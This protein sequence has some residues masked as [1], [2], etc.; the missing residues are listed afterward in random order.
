MQYKGSTCSDPPLVL[1]LSNLCGALAIPVLVEERASAKVL[2][3][4]VL[5][6]IQLVNPILDAAAT[7]LFTGHNAIGFGANASM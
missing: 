2:E 6:S 4:L 1:P 5:S 7:P 3:L